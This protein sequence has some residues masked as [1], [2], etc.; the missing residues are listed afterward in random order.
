MYEYSARRTVT[1]VCKKDR[2]SEILRF[3]C[4]IFFP[5]FKKYF[6]VAYTP[7]SLHVVLRC[8]ELALNLNLD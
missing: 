6:P 3:L 2:D 4:Q 1:N 8:G 5:D 7:P